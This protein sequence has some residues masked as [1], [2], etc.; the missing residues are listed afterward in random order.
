MGSQRGARPAELEPRIAYAL[1]RGAA[2]LLVGVGHALSGCDFSPAFEITLPQKIT[3][4]SVI[5]QGCRIVLMNDAFCEFAICTIS[6]PPNA[7]RTGSASELEYLS[8]NRNV[9]EI[10][11]STLASHCAVKHVPET[12]GVGLVRGNI[13]DPTPEAVKAVVNV[14]CRAVSS[15][16]DRLPQLV[17]QI[18]TL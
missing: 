14:C 2:M 7:P 13:W 12:T 16:F 1:T 17:N 9:L 3:A 10:C 4:E 15:A 18:L 6:R 8:E 5:F 11:K